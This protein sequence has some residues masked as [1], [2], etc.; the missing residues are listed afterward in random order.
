MRMDVSQV[1]FD[2]QVADAAARKSERMGVFFMQ[3]ATQRTA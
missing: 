3:D 1:Q 2:R